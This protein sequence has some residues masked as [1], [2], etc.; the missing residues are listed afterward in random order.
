MQETAHSLLEL[1]N[2]EILKLTGVQHIDVFEEEKIVLRT[3]QIR[4]TGDAAK[5]Y[6]FRFGIG[7]FTD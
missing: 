2:R 5:Y 3:R 1:K 6:S 4:N 7:Y